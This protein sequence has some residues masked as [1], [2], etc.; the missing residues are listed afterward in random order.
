MYDCNPSPNDTAGYLLLAE[1]VAR[2]A[3]TAGTQGREN[4]NTL[5][6]REREVA[7]L[8]ARGLTNR[9]IGDRLELSERTIE[10]HVARICRKLGFRRR[11]QIAA[12]IGEHDRRS[13][14]P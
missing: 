1:D 5:S 4:A 9:E 6:P 3:E 13:P 12:W 14:R 11:T 10:T 8:I 7:Q 2:T